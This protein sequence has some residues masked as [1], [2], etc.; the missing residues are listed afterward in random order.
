MRFRKKS[1]TAAIILLMA[2]GGGLLLSRCGTENKN[3]SK[4]TVAAA[5]YV[6]DISCKGCHADEHKEWSASHHFMAMLP[7]HDTTV[8]GNFDNVSLTADGV[9]SRFFKRDGKF[10]I[11]TEGEDGTNHDY[12]VKF[13]FGFTPL[14]QYLIEFPGG[15]MQVPR[16]SWDTKKKQWYHQYAGSKI[17]AHDWLHWT[18]NSQ[19]WNTMCASCHSTN[20][21]K[22]YNTDTETYQTTYNVINVSCESCHGPGSRHVEFVNSSDYVKG[23]PVPKGLFAMGKGASQ[24]EIVNT[25]ALCHSR[26]SDITGAVLPGKEFLDD[27]IPQTAT[28]EFFHADGLMDDEVYNY[29]S[30]LQSLMHRRGVKC[31]DCHNPHSG[32]LLKEGNL[33]CGNCHVPAQ[34]DVPEHTFHKSG[35]AAAECKNCHMYSQQYMGND[36]RHDHSFRVPRPDLSAKY[37]T[38]NACNGCHTEKTAQWAADA[39]VKWYGPTRKHHFSDDLVPGSRLDEKS[40]SHLQRLL[41]DTAV[42][43]IIRA[44]SA[45]YLGSILT[46]QSLESLLICLKDPDPH[47][48]YRTVRSLEGF[49]PAS[50]NTHAA[51]LLNDPVRAVRIAV[52]DLFV[53][54]PQNM[55]PESAMP[56]LESPRK[57]LEKFILYQSD[58]SVGNLMAGDYYTKTREYAVAEKYYRKALRMDSLMNYARLNL[59]A[60]QSSQGKNNDA[61]KTLNDAIIVD[62]RNDRAYYNKALLLAEM[63]DVTGA[64]E[65]FA[66][67]IALQTSNPRVYYNYGILLQQSEEPELAEKIFKKGISLDSLNGDLN[68]AL[69]VLYLNSG[70]AE[71]A[72]GPIEILRK[73]HNANP[74]FAAL[75]HQTTTGKR[76]Q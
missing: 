68:Y 46:P 51:P 52:A 34:Y 19:N 1:L 64:F 11:N 26:K 74:D 23:Q 48:R 54:L 24:N 25:C 49:D 53:G 15:R 44:T 63:N 59:S 10:I 70:K 57:E 66:K 7:A 27:F 72:D 40:F 32:N 41:N 29:T 75:L 12:E 47:V 73:Y 2:T 58:F 6:G 45:E 20:L 3:S 50:W 76:E 31:T 9:T 71:K 38:P 69:A 17:P 28:T 30:F 56:V 67:A 37:G 60:V 22:N 13:T 21:Q 8:L 4:E 33:M 18:G 42:P 62:P 39:V 43:G 14:Q 65:N 35:T 16:V 61:L 36:L 5:D 55:I